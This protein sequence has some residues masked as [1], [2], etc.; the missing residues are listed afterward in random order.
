MIN[1]M[2][3]IDDIVKHQQELL[4]HQR[5]QKEIQK[6]TIKLLNELNKNLTFM[7]TRLD[8]FSTRT[9]IQFDDNKATNKTTISS[10]LLNDSNN[11]TASPTQAVL[12]QPLST[13]L[14]MT[15]TNST[16]A[17]SSINKNPNKAQKVKEYF[18][19]TDNPTSTVKLNSMQAGTGLNVNKI[20]TSPSKSNNISS[21]INNV[22]TTTP[23]LT[24]TPTTTILLTNEFNLKNRSA[25][26][27]TG[28]SDESLD[29]DA[30]YD[31]S[32]DDEKET[33]QAKKKPKVI[34]LLS[35]LVFFVVVKFDFFVYWV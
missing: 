24:T 26:N 17:S 31:E 10:F 23:V 27:N 18:L 22:I 11:F 32:S 6:E 30:S 15:N 5:A 21:L 25:F 4:D 19:N 29:E 9:N 8:D 12:A 7:T 34:E 28:T 35:Y 1:Q 3:T 2:T 20:K 33:I 16:A 13:N 14:N